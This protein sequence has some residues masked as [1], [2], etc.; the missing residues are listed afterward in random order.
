MDFYQDLTTNFLTTMFSLSTTEIT[1]VEQV[2]LNLVDDQMKAQIKEKDVAVF[3]QKAES[4]LEASDVSTSQAEAVRYL[5]S[6]GI[7]ANTFE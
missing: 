5:L 1:K 7:V 2:T 4:A 3:C 6:K